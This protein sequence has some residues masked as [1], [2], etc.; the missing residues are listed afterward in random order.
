MNN[1]GNNLKRIRLLNNLSLREAGKLLN[2]SATAI[3]KYENGLIIPNS[4]KILDFAKAYK[5][6][7][8]DIL[9]SY[10]VPVIKFINF[11]KDG[12]INNNTLELLKDIIKNKISD[13][14]EVINLDN[15]FNYDCLKKY[16]CNSY[17]DIETIANKFRSDYNLSI[18]QPLS[19]LINILE[20]IGIIIITIQNID[21]KFN[22]F[23][24]FSEIIN[25][26][27]IIVLL[28]LDDGAR[29]RFTIVHELGHL[30]L[31]INKNLD[32]EIAC[33]KFASCFLMPKDCVIKEFGK[34]RKSI[35]FLELLFFKKEYKVSLK[36]IIHRLK[37]LDI[38]NES[39]YKSINIF[40][41]QKKKNNQ[42]IFN[43]EKEVSYQ[44]Q[45]IVY[46]LENRN[47]ISSSR[48]CEL[49]GVSMNEK[50]RENNNY[51]Y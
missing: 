45:R 17:D 47:I 38:I 1:I 33:N 25:G 49:L 3:S 7:A 26:I 40:L 35:S 36:A 43:V 6:K 23:D 21:N 16:S 32:K 22:N 19:N 5:V 28:D 51:R 39:L 18:N 13:Y 24:G 37:E 10:N 12:N 41:N 48:A 34:S 9:R 11:R 14:L 15:S 29:E 31:D 27:P 20:N 50:E 8:R 30:I 44:F 4:S 42:E 46:K 2:M